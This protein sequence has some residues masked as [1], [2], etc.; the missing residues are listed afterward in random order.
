MAI[1]DQWRYVIHA[2]PT[3]TNLSSDNSERFLLLRGAWGTRNQAAVEG[4]AVASA[5]ATQRERDDRIVPYP[6]AEL[7]EM[8]KEMAKYQADGFSFGV[9]RTKERIYVSI[10]IN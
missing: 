4:V 5:I 9:E 8:A 1:K 10:E 6:R 7:Q 3:G 2:V